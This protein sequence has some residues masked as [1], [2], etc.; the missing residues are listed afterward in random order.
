MALGKRCGLSEAE[1]GKAVNPNT[2]YVK[3]AIQEVNIMQVTNY[4]DFI[5]SGGTKNIYG[6]SIQNGGT[7]EIHGDNTVTIT[8]KSIV[9]S[10]KELDTHI[11]AIKN[12]L[13]DISKDDIESINNSLDAIYGELTKREP[14]KNILRLCIS[15][16]EPFLTITNGGFDFTKNLQDLINIVHSHL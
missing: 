4:G 16:L 2:A 1:F 9:D 15:V 7:K 12:N 8:S 14:K 6:D 13:P 10:T 11:S 3:K 5:Q